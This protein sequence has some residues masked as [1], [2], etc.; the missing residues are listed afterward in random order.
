MKS[1]K[2]IA[3][4]VAG[5]VF[6]VGAGYIVYSGRPVVTIQNTPS[7]TSSTAIGTVQTY[8]AA[9]VQTHKSPSSCWSIIGGDVYDLTSWISRHPGGA[10][11]ILGLCGTDGTDAYTNQHGNSRRP[12]AA[13]T[14]LKIG[15]LKQ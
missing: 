15:S 11:V 7:G 1:P 10:E 14:L 5:L 8:T 13:L 9:D 12:K 6:L 3:A 4:M 2:I